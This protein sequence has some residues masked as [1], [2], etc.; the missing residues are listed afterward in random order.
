MSKNKLETK[1]II[2]KTCYYGIN[3]LIFVEWKEVSDL[4]YVALR[5]FRFTSTN[6]YYKDK[7]SI[8]YVI[9]LKY[10]V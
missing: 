9:L 4:V 10:V 7:K 6:L 8:T 1:L 3:E 2:C 5:Y